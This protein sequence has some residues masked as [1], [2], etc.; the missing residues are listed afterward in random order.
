ML[1]IDSLPAVNHQEA[2]A[3]ATITPAGEAAIRDGALSMAWT[4]IDLAEGDRWEELGAAR[5]PGAPTG[6]G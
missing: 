6:S 5:A 3:A 4:V 1:S 2:F